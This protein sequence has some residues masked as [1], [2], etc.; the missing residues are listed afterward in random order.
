MNAKQ[1]E[2]KIEQIRNYIDLFYSEGKLISDEDVAIIDDLK[3]DFIMY[4]FMLKCYTDP[5]AIILLEHL[6]ISTEEALIA[7]EEYDIDFLM[8]FCSNLS[9]DFSFLLPYILQKQLNH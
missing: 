6:G 9:Y 8:C 3:S 4:S 2:D 1:L 5:K 7:I